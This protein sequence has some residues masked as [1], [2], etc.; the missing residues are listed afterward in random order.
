[1]NDAF[2]RL[3]LAR[4][5]GNE[6]QQVHESSDLPS[7]DGSFAYRKALR[8]ENHALTEYKRI[9]AIYTDLVLHGKIPEVES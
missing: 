5:A 2:L 7:A 8:A 1:M 6:A 4:N 9:L 3:Q